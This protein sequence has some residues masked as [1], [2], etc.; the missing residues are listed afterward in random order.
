MG[1]AIVFGVISL[2]GL[3]VTLLSRHQTITVTIQAPP[4]E[5]VRLITDQYPD[6]DLDAFLA[7]HEDRIH[8]LGLDDRSRWMP[9]EVRIRTRYP[10]ND[11][12]G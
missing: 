12:L 5:R 9:G 8:T 6:E 11:R 10:D 1:L 7:R 2:I 3:V 4:R